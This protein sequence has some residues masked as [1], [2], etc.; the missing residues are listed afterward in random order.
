ILEAGRRTPSSRNEQRWDLVLCTEREQ[1][2]RLSHVWRGAGHV[3]SSAATVALCA[4]VEA[5]ARVRESIPYDLGQITMSMMLAAAD[6]GIGSGHSSVRD[7]ALAHEILGLPVDRTCAWLVAFGYPAD[8]PLSPI[9]RP[10][11][12]SFDDVVHRTN[13]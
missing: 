1:L 8:H 4:P 3:A 10:D 7:D 6:L 2:Q 9:A 11:R 13:W 12:R 5:D